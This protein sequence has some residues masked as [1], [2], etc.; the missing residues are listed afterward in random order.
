MYR[1]RMEH[2]AVQTV[3]RMLE[4]E[5]YIGTYVIGKRAVTEIGGH[6]IRLKDES[7]WYKI[8]DHHPAIVSKELFEQAK[9]GIRRF[10]IQTKSSMITLYA[11]SVLRLLRPCTVTDYTISEVLLSALPGKHGFC[12]SWYVGQAEEL[13]TAVFQIIRAQ[14]DTVLGVDG[15][16]KD[17]LDLQVIQQAEYEKKVQVLQDAKTAAL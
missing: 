8:P 5:R 3:L 15:D 17:N 6:R 7:E 11:E 16:G 14:V 9:A 10:S 12:L 13:E 4:D 1:G 2:G